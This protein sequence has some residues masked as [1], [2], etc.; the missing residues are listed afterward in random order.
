[1][2]QM[3]NFLA[4]G[5][6]RYVATLEAGSLYFPNKIT[7]P[8][9]YHVRSLGYWREYLAIGTY[10]GEN[11]SDYQEGK[12]FFWDGIS[13]TYNFYISV[14]EG[15]VNAMFG[16]RDLLFV[17]AGSKGEILV[18]TGQ[19]NAEKLEQIPRVET[20]EEI[21]VSPGAVNMYNTL[22]CFGI[23]IESDSSNLYK[24]LYT[25]GTL[26]KNYPYSLGFDYETSLG[27]QVSNNVKIGMVYPSG[28]DLYIGWS[29][30]NAFGIDKI[31]MD[32]DQYA[33]ASIEQL[34]VDADKISKDK[35]NLIVRAD[36]SALES[37]QEIRVKYKLDRDD[38]W[39]YSDW[40][41]TEGAEELRL[42]IHNPSKE[43]QIGADL[44]ST[45]STQVELYGLSVQLE[46][47]DQR[48]I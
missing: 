15:G 4:I 25:Y 12:I 48:E 3:L 24:G 41:D 33:T 26:N 27:E 38:A 44:S 2:L 16:T 45:I 47:G 17:S 18:Y 37:G 6:G 14:P 7:L 36:F 13:D 8:S 46:D 28:G 35:V 20:G 40:E 22:I 10:Q 43:I 31:D 1:M 9:G 39:I 5:N 30:S 21:E 42:R 32:N 23:A 11:L 29:N 34:I 19:G